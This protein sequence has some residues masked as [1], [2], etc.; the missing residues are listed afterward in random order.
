MP[1]KKTP[2]PINTS[3]DDPATTY[4]R[5]VA[6]G[7]LPAGPHVRGACE[8]HLRDL[9]D[10]SKRGLAWDVA[11]AARVIGYFRDV[12]R[13]NGGEHEGQPFH[14]LP[15]QAFCIGSLFGWKGSDGHRRFRMAY[16]EG[17]KGSGKSPLAAG[18]GLYLQ[19]ADSE[20][21]AE[22]Y[23][24]ASKLDQARVLFRD[25]VAMVRQSP[26]LAARLTFSGGPGREYNIAD[27]ARGSFFRPIASE[28]GQSGP[29]PHGALLDEIH[30]HPDN[31]MVEM[32]RAGTKG[33]RQAI[34]LMITNSG[35]DRTGVCWQYHEYARKVC[36][37]DLEDDAF[38]AYVC[39]LDDGEDP[40]R[41]EACWTKANPSLGVTFGPKYLRE[42]V[43][44]AR[45]MPAKEAIVRRL[46]FCEWTDAA[47]PWI[48]RDL[49][50]ACEADFDPD[51][52]IGLPCWGGLDLSAK[53][54]LTSLAVCW[55]HPDGTLSLA[56][57]FWT[58]G[59][60][61]DERAR[62]DGVP[63]RLW[64]DQGYLHAPPGRIIDKG[65]VATFVQQI[66]ITHDMQTLAFDQAQIEDFQVA[67]D[68]IG[69]ETWIDDRQR[70]ENGAAKGPEGAGLR[71][72]RHGQG[73]A[74]YASQTA[75]WM[76]RSI[77]ATEDAIIKLQIR[78]R[79]NPVL[80]YNSASAVLESD[81]QGNRRWT[82][83]KSTGRIDGIVAGSMAVGAARA[84]RP[85]VAPSIWDRAD[86]WENA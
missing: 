2:P 68:D 34:I 75:L 64:V 46:N 74:G 70:D 5:Q 60:T 7:S 71:M 62:V 77:G 56:A 51:E 47:A 52:L 26:H 9:R 83:R 63:Y 15:W 55:E 20:P 38:F 18:I 16:I 76:P 29:R 53:R 25:A 67:C 54:D 43:T 36:A 1:R 37:G 44:Q 39:A 6:D 86:L 4:A 30:E 57:W 72:M 10:G 42:Q 31:E 65:H 85:R 58:P 61:V 81:P 35:S 49:W 32:M 3:P 17:G 11:A 24:A 69:F 33:R 59:D 40:F 48:D 79:R 84:P 19:T 23:A 27:I 14:L 8:R 21:R 45:G 78:I 82:K 73:F 28:N 50:D 12:L 66:A 41:D 80:R 13:L 22:I